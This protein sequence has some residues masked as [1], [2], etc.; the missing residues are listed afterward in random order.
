MVED[1]SHVLQMEIAVREKMLNTGH[2]NDPLWFTRME[3]CVL[4]VKSPS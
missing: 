2:T 3:N 4:Q 1:G